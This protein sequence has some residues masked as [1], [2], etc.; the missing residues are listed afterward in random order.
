MANW[1][2]KKVVKLEDG[3]VCAAPD[4]LKNQ[5]LRS[6]NLT[7]YV[8]WFDDCPDICDCTCHWDGYQVYTE[9]SCIQRGLKEI[10][11]VFPDNLRMLDLSR[12]NIE[13]FDSKEIL[14]F[15][16][17]EQLNLEHNS[18]NKVMICIS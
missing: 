18:I 17:L 12:N 11:K 15:A 6:L 2:R 16:N 8:R 5:T 4:H 14:G 13:S 10:P 9:A 1:V 3:P 7:D